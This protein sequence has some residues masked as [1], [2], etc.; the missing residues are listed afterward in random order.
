MGE[1]LGRSPAAVQRFQRIRDLPKHFPAPLERL[2]VHHPTATEPGKGLLRTVQGGQPMS[3]E[4][5]LLLLAVL[6]VLAASR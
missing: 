3:P 4:G 5:A 1:S 6:L 2:N